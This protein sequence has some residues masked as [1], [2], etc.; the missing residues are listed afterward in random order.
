MTTPAHEAL[1]ELRSVCPQYGW[2]RFDVLANVIKEE[3][4]QVYDCE[5]SSDKTHIEAQEQGNLL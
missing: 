2:P 1:E 3:L 5:A 4:A